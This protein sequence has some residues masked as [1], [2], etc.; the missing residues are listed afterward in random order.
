[1]LTFQ[2]SKEK[3][4]ATAYNTKHSVGNPYKMHLTNANGFNINTKRTGTEILTTNQIATELNGKSTN[5]NLFRLNLLE[6]LVKQKWS[7]SKNVLSG[8]LHQKTDSK[9][10]E[11][12]QRIMDVY[13]STT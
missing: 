3:P 5:C 8:P 13:G 9:Q 1:M 4:K 2:N 6:S 10:S 7:N 11:K 12:N